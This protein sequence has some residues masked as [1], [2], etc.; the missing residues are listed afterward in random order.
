MLSRN[1]LTDYLVYMD[2]AYLTFSIPNFT[3]SVAERVSGRKRYY[4]ENGLLNN[5]LF[6]G[7]AKLPENPVAITL[8][9]VIEK[10]RK[11]ACFSII[12]V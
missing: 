7:E 9:S 5:F 10:K 3:D 1:T 4:Y 8:L 11:K 2:D 6:N 12:K